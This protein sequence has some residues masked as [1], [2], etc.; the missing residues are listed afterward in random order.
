M[1]ALAAAALAAG[2]L[3]C[4]F[5]DGYRKSLLAAINNDPP[6]T[7][8]LLLYDLQ[9]SQVLQGGKAGRREVAVREGA[10]WLH[11]IQSEGPSVRVTTLT[12]CT[13]GEEAACTRFAA[14]HAWHFDA[15]VQFDP[16]GAFARQPSGAASGTC[17]PWRVEPS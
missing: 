1:N 4:E 13:R 8:L 7:E 2:E 12:A 6:R 17:E 16:D 10:Q 5:D 15:S 3:L 9:A 14:T 11:L